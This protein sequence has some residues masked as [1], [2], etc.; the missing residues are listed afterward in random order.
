MVEGKNN[1]QEITID[2]TSWVVAM[3]ILAVVSIV[4]VAIVAMKR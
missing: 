4:V 1:P 2:L 3:L